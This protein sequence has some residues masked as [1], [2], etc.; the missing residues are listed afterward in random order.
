MKRNKKFKYIEKKVL[1]QSYAAFTNQQDGV[2]GECFV[3]LKNI[4]ETHKNVIFFNKKLYSLMF[5]Q[6]DGV[7]EILVMSTHKNV[8]L[9]DSNKKEEPKKST[10]EVS[11]QIFIDNVCASYRHDFG[12]LSQEDQ[13]MLRFELKEWIRALNNTLGSY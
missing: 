4:Y 8:Y 13:D 11:K 1:K 2:D 3:L 7:E 12:L 10:I 6:H 5:R 9:V